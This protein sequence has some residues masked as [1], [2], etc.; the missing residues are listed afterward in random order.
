ME[1]PLEEAQKLVYGAEGGPP[2]ILHDFDTNTK[3]KPRPRKR[4]KV[5]GK[6]YLSP[7]QLAMAIKRQKGLTDDDPCAC[8]LPGDFPPELTYRALAAYS[9]LRTLSVE[10]RLSPFTPN[11]FLRALYLPYPNRMMGQIHV[12]LLRMLLPNLQMGYSYKQQGGAI[13]VTKRRHIDGIRWPLRAGDNLTYLDGLSWPLFYDDYCH[14]TADKLWAAMNDKELH[15]DFR[16]IDMIGVKDTYREA[17][18][19]EEDS[20]EEDDTQVPSFPASIPTPSRSSAVPMTS[21]VPLEDSPPPA[22]LKGRRSLPIKGRGAGSAAKAKVEIDSDNCGDSQ[23]EYDSET[24]DEKDDEEL[25]AWTPKS[26]KRKSQGSGNRGRFRKDGP[27]FST[28]PLATSKPATSQ[29]VSIIPS[30]VS[31]LRTPVSKD[32]TAS[33]TLLAK[34]ISHSFSKVSEVTGA[35]AQECNKPAVTSVPSSQ[36]FRESSKAAA[37]VS[38]KRED[39]SPIPMSTSEKSSEAATLEKSSTPAKSTVQSSFAASVDTAKEETHA[40]VPAKSNLQ[41]SVPSAPVTSAVLSSQ[42][43]SA[44][45]NKEE[46]SAVAAAAVQSFQTVSEF[47]NK[48]DP[49]A[50]ATEKSS[51]QHSVPCAPA[52]SSIV[53]PESTD[54]ASSSTDREEASSAEEQH[55]SAVA[56]T[57]D[58]MLSV[59][60]GGLSVAAT[61][62]LKLSQEAGA[63]TNKEE[64]SGQS[65]S[66][67]EPFIS[68]GKP[69]HMSSDQTEESDES[70][71]VESAEKETKSEANAIG[72][73]IV[74]LRGGGPG[75]GSAEDSSAMEVEPS[76]AAIPKGDLNGEASNTERATAMD[77]EPSESS[78]T[79]EASEAATPTAKDSQL[80]ESTGSLSSSKALAAPGETV[81]AS[82]ALPA[83]G[84]QEKLDKASTSSTSSKP[85]NTSGRRRMLPMARKPTLSGPIDS[86]SP[87]NKQTVEEA[88]ANMPASSSP[89]GIPL[90][91]QRPTV[92]MAGENGNQEQPLEQGSGQKRPL[93]RQRKLPVHSSPSVKKQ[94]QSSSPIVNPSQAAMQMQ[95]MQQLQMQQ[96]KMQQMQQNMMSGRYNQFAA[97]MAGKPMGPPSGFGIVNMGAYG[98]RVASTHV[99]QFPMHMQTQGG[100]S[101]HPPMGYA[102]MAQKPVAADDDTLRVKPYGVSSDISETIHN[103]IAG[104]EMEQQ[105]WPEDDG[106]TQSSKEDDLDERESIQ[107]DKHW[108]Q[109]RPIKTM[110]SGVPYH[111]LPLDQKLDILEFLIDELLSVEAIAAE[112]SKRQAIS[113]CYSFPY[114]LLPTKEEFDNLENEDECGVCQGEGDLLC[115][116]GCV[117]SYHRTCLDMSKNQVL[118]EGKWLCPECKLVDPS[119]FGPLLGGRKASLDWFTADS[120]A[121]ASSQ[122]PGLPVS[123]NERVEVSSFLEAVGAGINQSG[124]GVEFAAE[125]QSDRSKGALLGAEQSSGPTVSHDQVSSESQLMLGVPLGS[126]WKPSNEQNLVSSKGANLGDHQ[127]SERGDNSS[128]QILSIQAES[129][130]SPS[131]KV[132][133]SDVEF[134]V[135]HGYVFSKPRACTTAGEDSKLMSEQMF[136][137]LSRDQI[138]KHLKDF[139]SELSASWPFAQIP[140]HVASTTSCHFPSAKVYF[141]PLE[142]F[143]PSFYASK[144]RKAPLSRMMKTGAGSQ[145]TYLVL[146][147]YESECG[148]SN[149]YRVTENLIRDMTLDKHIASSLRSDLSLFDPYQMIKSYMTR[150]ENT[151]RKACLLNEFWET[152]KRRAR[153]EMWLD[154][155]RKC[156]SINRLAL[157][158]MRLVDTVHPRAFSDGWFHNPLGKNSEPTSGATVTDRNYLPLP[159]GWSPENELRIRRWQRTPMSSMLSLLADEGCPLADVVKGIRVESGRSIVAPRS[160]RKQ[161]KLTNSAVT[162]QES[163]DGYSRDEGRV[164]ITP[165][166][167]QGGKRNE[168]SAGMDAPVEMETELK[169]TEVHGSVIGGND[170]TADKQLAPLKN[171]VV[172]HPLQGNISL[173]N[174]A[175]VAAF[176]PKPSEIDA[177][178]KAEFQDIA[179]LGNER[180]IGMDDTVANE[181]EFQLSPSGSDIYAP[182]QQFHGNGH[183]SDSRRTEKAAGGDPPI[184]NEARLHLKTPETVENVDAPTPPQLDEKC[185]DGAS[186]SAQGTLP[187]HDHDTTKE[188]ERENEEEKQQEAP[189]GKKNIKRRKKEKVA[190]TVATN[191]RTRRSGRFQT[192]YPEGGEALA[193]PLSTVETRAAPGLAR[194]QFMEEQKI[195]RIPELEK[196]VKGSFQA[197]LHWP[198]AGR[199]HFAPF[200]SL[201]PKEMRRLGR[202]AGCI[203]SPH[204]VYSKTH[205]VGQLCLSHLW[206]TKTE[207]CIGFEELLLQIRVLNSFLDKPVSTKSE[208]RCSQCQKY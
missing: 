30:A 99:G 205:E 57:D 96:M 36:R 49:S 108:P 173:R 22:E 140:S 27:A 73:Q 148:Q 119:L 78:L 18:Y 184:E 112:F 147:D 56:P 138:R 54:L 48:E 83:G 161:S 137:P 121:I 192:G 128:Q 188:G 127:S 62:T 42:T 117:S 35:E 75:N 81:P 201:S 39:L 118:P 132:V 44:F 183:E 139:G 187:D 79:I 46:A 172:L 155:V 126:D 53:G 190:M 16:Y 24:E 34:N 168:N 179:G 7:Q 135:V 105:T 88:S 93:G 198:L 82:L 103:F 167:A 91:M 15:L 170:N 87:V 157:L 197:Q 29:P 55:S 80:N 160:K 58:V 149:T 129:L 111:R 206:R 143:D 6:N 189:E 123:V 31:H 166:D 37:S 196:F 59:T 50:T 174:D 150:L 12:S 115:C 153:S 65:A 98:N 4:A 69:Q 102:S 106:A 72:S 86:Q 77:V 84:K 145:H 114:G 41:S 1:A 5:K 133:G 63:P 164:S 97:A 113:D 10:L 158:L 202:N 67:E 159:K 66:K 122:F 76:S 130:N 13:G 199:S 17:C 100:W 47:T 9:L 2:M 85:G 28:P 162:I 131:E 51:S 38:V 203:R 70:K 124:L 33:T 64:I 60:K 144:Y 207:N 180:V 25:P 163:A 3:A 142:S 195:V 120:I 32:A 40:P 21:R 45:N 169:P 61:S 176:Q 109:F 151:L 204:V 146:S 194:G 154:S 125:V 95:Q 74:N 191:R 175:P 182:K 90:P 171:Q 104:R 177:E 43:V 8:T 52:T 89:L 11:V 107:D 92:N 116:D 68:D 193:S 165:G 136:L 19:V 186:H 156:M 14:L 141:A 94:K 178:L 134:L 110:R 71:A 200:G 185:L 152:G 23:S 26:R 181:A 208:R 20:D 101:G